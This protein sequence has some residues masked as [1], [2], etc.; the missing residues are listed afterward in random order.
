[1]RKMREGYRDDE[2]GKKERLSK[3]MRER[4]R[5]RAQNKYIVKVSKGGRDGGREVGREGG[6]ERGREGGRAKLIKAA[7][8]LL[9]LYLVF[10]LI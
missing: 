3:E 4:E 2:K 9:I 8:Y 10:F 5:E 7:D 6:R 1:M